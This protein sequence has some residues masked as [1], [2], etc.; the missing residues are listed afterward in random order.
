MLEPIPLNLALNMLAVAVQMTIPFGTNLSSVTPSLVPHKGQL[1]YGL[2]NDQLY[3]A[4]DVEWNL[5]APCCVGVTATNHDKSNK[6]RYVKEMKTLETAIRDLQ[7]RVSK[8]E[9][10]NRK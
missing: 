4:N 5:V 10:R 8:L 1:A 3:L 7:M 9:E 2:D 6:Y